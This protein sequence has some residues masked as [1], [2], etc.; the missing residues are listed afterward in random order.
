MINGVQLAAKA[1][2]H[3]PADIRGAGSAGIRVDVLKPDAYS[4]WEKGFTQGCG[5]HRK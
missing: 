1:N 5:S 2:S 3:L 4:V